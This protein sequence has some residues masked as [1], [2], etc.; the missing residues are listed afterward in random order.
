MA[1]VKKNR[2]AWKISFIMQLSNFRIYY[3]KKISFAKY[4]EELVNGFGTRLMITSW[5]YID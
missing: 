4:R 3:I 2:M 5:E 1:R